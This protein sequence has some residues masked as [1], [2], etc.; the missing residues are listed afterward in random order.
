MTKGGNISLWAQT[1]IGREAISKNVKELWKDE[2]YN[3]KNINPVKCIE[4][5]YIF[6]SAKEAADILQISASCI[7][8]CCR[9]TQKSAGG[10]CWEISSWNE[11]DI[12]YEDNQNYLE[13]F[14]KEVEIKKNNKKLLKLNKNKMTTKPILCIDK[15]IAYKGQAVAAKITGIDRS[16]IGSCCL[17]KQK[18]CGGYQWKFIEEGE[19]IKYQQMNRA[20]IF[21][22]MA[23]STK[24]IPV[25]C[26][27]TNIV[28]KCISDATKQT[29]INNIYKCCKGLIKTAGGYHWQIVND[30]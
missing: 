29:G 26:V 13:L 3:R 20:D 18:L 15:D 4:N 30:A 10:Y 21:I 27:E 22:P 9:G 28:Y 14:L 25:R 6:R 5:N 12:F 1:E 11:Y 16:G 7:R 19:Y 23:K 24:K 2:Q 17:G 8:G